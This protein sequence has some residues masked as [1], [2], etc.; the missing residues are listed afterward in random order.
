M[1]KRSIRLSIITQKAKIPSLRIYL[2]VKNVERK[3][4]KAVLFYKK[5]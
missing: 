4:Q 2:K 5:S 3:S 1:Q